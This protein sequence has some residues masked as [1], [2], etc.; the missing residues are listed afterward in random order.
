MKQKLNT[1]KNNPEFQK[2]LQ[3]MKPSRSIWG[4]LGVVVVFFVPEIMSYFWSNEIN[5]YFA[6]LAQTMPSEKMASLLEFLGKELFNGEVSWINI[7]LGVLF[8]VWLFRK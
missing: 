5:H 4:V 2:K 3:K 7:G 1:I 8:L 6:N